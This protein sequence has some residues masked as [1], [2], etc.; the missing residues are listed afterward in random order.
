MEK[1]ILFTIGIPIYKMAKISWLS[2]ESLCNQRGL[3]K[4]IFWE[5][6]IYE[7]CLLQDN[8]D[9]CYKKYFNKYVERL[10]KVGCLR[11]V[12]LSSEEYVF[13]EQK[14]SLIARA[15][16]ETSEYFLLQGADDY[17]YPKRLKDTYDAIKKYKPDLIVLDNSY[18][19]DINQDKMIQFIC[20]DEKSRLFLT[21][22]IEWIKEL[23]NRFIGKG[24]DGYIL[25]EVRRQKESAIYKIVLHNSKSVFTDG[26]NHISLH[27]SKLY[28]NPKPPFFETNKK[29]E[30][31]LPKYIAKRL[32]NLKNKQ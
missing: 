25:D 31:I 19:Y 22:R 23:R 30:N 2:L 18:G 20:N 29:I 9:C 10:K 14:W 1:K 16:S 11:I 15:A 27:R 26:F 28:N 13:L 12:Y 6:I 4:G 3:K 24:V 8:E 17:S 5:L 21:T 32:K 7:D